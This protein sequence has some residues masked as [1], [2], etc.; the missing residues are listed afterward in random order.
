VND[1]ISEEMTMKQYNL[2]I[3]DFYLNKY[4]QN[5]PVVARKLGISPATIYRMI[6]DR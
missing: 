2:K 1:L 3:L 4:N 6:K 5:I